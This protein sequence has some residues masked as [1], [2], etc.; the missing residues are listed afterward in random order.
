MQWDNQGRR[1]VKHEQL[2]SWYR[3]IL[4]SD[5]LL[6]QKNRKTMPDTPMDL[7][8]LLGYR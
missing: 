5:I 8:S 2:L 6:A 1:I 4:S 7:D 3:K